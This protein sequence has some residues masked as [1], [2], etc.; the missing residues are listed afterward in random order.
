M[1]WPQRWTKLGKWNL[2]KGLSYQPNRMVKLRS[3]SVTLAAL[4]SSPCT[5]LLQATELK[6]FPKGRLGPEVSLPDQQK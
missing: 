5:A 2:R 4:C 6:L 3:V 1:A